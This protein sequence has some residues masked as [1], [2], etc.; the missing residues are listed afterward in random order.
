[1]H[2]VRSGR[3]N[4]AQ[5]FL[6]VGLKSRLQAYGHAL[7]ILCEGMLKSVVSAE[8]LQES[9]VTV[10]REHSKQFATLHRVAGAIRQGDLGAAFA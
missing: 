6:K 3:D 7:P 10:P 5:V 4:I 2:L 1:M 9:G 8:C